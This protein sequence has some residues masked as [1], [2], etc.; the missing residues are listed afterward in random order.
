MALTCARSEYAGYTNLAPHIKKVPSISLGGGKSTHS[1]YEQMASGSGTAYINCGDAD[2]LLMIGNAAHPWP[3]DP[4]T[5]ILVDEKTPGA[6]SMDAT[7]NIR[8][9]CTICQAITMPLTAHGF[10]A[11]LS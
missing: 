1:G 11:G 10:E 2:R 3:T 9:Q 6:V 7:P 5:T 4:L 8:A